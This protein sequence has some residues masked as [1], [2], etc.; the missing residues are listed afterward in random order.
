MDFTR[1]PLIVAQ[2]ETAAAVEAADT[3][4]NVAGIDV[5]FVG[6]ADLQRDLDAQPSN[7]RPDFETCVE[8]VAAVA[9]A[10]GK[11]A[12]ILVRDPAE[13]L[14]RRRQGFTVIAVQS[15]LALLRDA[16]V[17]TIKKIRPRS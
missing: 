6:P 16:F 17:T 9:R 4:A 10:A 2:I 5:L 14:V 3:I 8:R 7:L 13:V 15:D 11:A 1:Q 12:G